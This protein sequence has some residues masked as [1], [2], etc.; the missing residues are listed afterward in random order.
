MGETPLVTFAAIAII[1]CSD[2]FQEL[3]LPV[4]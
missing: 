1:E 3:Q 4:Q 2:D